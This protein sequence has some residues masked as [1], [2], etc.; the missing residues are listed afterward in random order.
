[1]ILSHI[2]LADLKCMTFIN[3]NCDKLPNKTVTA[4]ALS[5]YFFLSTV[6]VGIVDGYVYHPSTIPQTSIP[7]DFRYV[8]VLIFQWVKLFPSK[9]G[10]LMCASLSGLAILMDLFLQA[11]KLLQKALLCYQLLEIILRGGG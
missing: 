7:S 10:G 11:I 4:L 2:S 5:S 3:S 1:M 6:S 8:V 9:I